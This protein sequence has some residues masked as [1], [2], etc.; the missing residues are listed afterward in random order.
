MRFRA[1]LIIGLCS[2]CIG[3]FVLL[4]AAAGGYHL[5]K[6]IPLGAAGGGGEYFDYITVDAAARRA[7]LS[8]GTEIVV[9]NADTGVSVGK[10]IGMKRNHG[11]ALVPELDRGFITDGDAAQVVMFDLKTLK[12]I[13]TIKGEMDA[14]S[15][16]YEPVSKHVFVFNG[17][18]KSSTV[19]DPAKGTVI[20]TIPLGGAPEQAVAD[21]KGMIYDNLEDTNEVIALDART[22]KIQ[23]R[24]KVA[25]AGQPVSMAMDRQSRRLFIGGRNPKLLVVMDA[26]SGK[27][28]GEPFPIGDRVDS[29]LFDP[30]TQLLA[31]STREG[32]IHIFHEDSPNK[33]SVVETVKTEFGA[34]TMGLDSKTHNLLVDTSDFEMPAPTPQQP[35]PQPRAK[36]GTFRLLI[37]GR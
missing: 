16:L 36:P 12:T 17:D 22:L 29:N 24:W 33:L 21:G 26:D 27:I 23:S 4:A 18:P 5:L 28:I 35:N 3:A 8:H 37:Y 11:V 9:L 30:E 19:I 6:K 7:Y 32:A 13:G 31:S 34:K 1:R 14:D 15:I 20:A 10:I 25:P 2:L